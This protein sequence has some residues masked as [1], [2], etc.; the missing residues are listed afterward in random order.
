MTERTELASLYARYKGL[1]LAV[2]AG[3]L[4]DGDGASGLGAETLR[5]AA[6]AGRMREADESPATRACHEAALTLHRLATAAPD[7]SEHAQL[8]DAVRATHRALRARLWDD[9]AHQYAPCGAHPHG[10][11]E[12]HQHA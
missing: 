8:I 12:E 2:G 9:V 10:H 7:D 4:L 6:D 3:L 1:A 11:K 5:L